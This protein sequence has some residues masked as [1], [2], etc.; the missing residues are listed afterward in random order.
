MLTVADQQQHNLEH[1]SR[2]GNCPFGCEEVFRKLAGVQ[3]VKRTG[4]GRKQVEGGSNV[5]AEPLLRMFDELA[6]EVGLSFP[7]EFDAL[8]LDENA[9][10]SARRLDNHIER[11]SVAACPRRPLLFEVRQAVRRARAGVRHRRTLRCT[12]YR[13]GP[14]QGR[15]EGQGRR[16]ALRPRGGPRAHDLDQGQRAVGRSHQ[17]E[18][19]DGQGLHLTVRPLHDC[20]RGARAGRCRRRVVP[21]LG[22]AAEG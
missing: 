7:K 12:S 14:V 13:K 16:R 6:A 3:L 19:A 9:N 1:V 21:E 5:G 15:R 20:P 22:C 18:L 4:V 2:F 11:R 10:G 17:E 8:A